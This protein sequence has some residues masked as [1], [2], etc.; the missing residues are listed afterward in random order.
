ML[1][2]RRVVAIH[3]P[4][5]LP[6]LGYF[7]K[8]A[9]ADVFVV[10]DN[11][12]LTKT[13]GSWV[14]RVRLVAGGR[15]VWATAPVERSYHGVRAIREIRLATG[16]WR[17]KL[18]ETVRAGYARA[19]YFDAVFPW[20]RELLTNPEDRL[21]DY[22]LHAIHSLRAVLRLDAGMLVRAS[23]LSVEG[24]GTALL[25]ALVQAVGGEAYLCGGGAAGYQDSAAFAAVGLE[26]VEQAFRHPVYPQTAP[27]FVAGL[28]VVDALMRCGVEGTRELIVQSRPGLAGGRGTGAARPVAATDRA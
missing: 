8:I 12:Q 25:V 9:H 3:Q 24:R 26:V 19:P 6:W 21:A 15:V 18:V 1:H 22:N 20:L 13:G 11:V 2:G 27:E 5:F 7:N 16:P 14:N 4:N 10:L 28:S 23:S 17:R